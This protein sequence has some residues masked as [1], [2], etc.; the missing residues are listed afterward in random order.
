MPALLAS[1]L[2]YNKDVRYFSLE[3]AEAKIPR[4]EEIFGRVI[5]L[6]EQVQRKAASYHRLEKNQISNP[7]DV[8]IAKGQVDFL[9]SQIKETLREVVDMGAVPKGLDP[10]LVDFP[11]KVEDR[12][13]FLCWRFGEKFISYHHNLEEGY[14]SRK[15]LPINITASKFED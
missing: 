3:E 14:K 12:D 15:L 4:L 2:I 6:Q 5:G 13:I 10:Y 9:V 1:A 7:V 11:A 8:L